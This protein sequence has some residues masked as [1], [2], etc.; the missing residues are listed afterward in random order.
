MRE[1]GGRRRIVIIPAGKAL[2]IG[3]DNVTLFPLTAVM[4]YSQ[5]TPT[6]AQI[7]NLS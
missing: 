6:Q 1:R 7:Y 2:V 3:I 4:K 5:A